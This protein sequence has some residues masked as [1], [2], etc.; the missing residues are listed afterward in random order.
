MA[1]MITEECIACDECREECPNSAIDVDDPHYIIDP[2]RCTECI[3]YDD[4]PSCVPVCPVDALIPDP[5]NIESIDELK[6]KYERLQ[7]EE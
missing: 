6:Y 5:D 4:E 2:D 1:L 3:G 7:K